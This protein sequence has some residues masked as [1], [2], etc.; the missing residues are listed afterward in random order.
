MRA[1]AKYCTTR[2]LKM[3][4]H[5][6]SEGFQLGIDDPIPLSP[7]TPPSFATRRPVMD[8]FAGGCIAVLAVL[9]GCTWLAAGAGLMG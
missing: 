7:L 6:R 2:E 5:W 4:T 1:Q 9:A 3:L 8:A